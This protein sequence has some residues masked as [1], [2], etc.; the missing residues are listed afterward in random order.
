MRTKFQ[1]PQTTA[2]RK[3]A[4]AEGKPLPPESVVVYP[5]PHQFPFRAGP[6]TPPIVKVGTVIHDEYYGDVA[7]AGM[8]KAPIPWPGFHQTRGLH[9]GVMPILFADLVRA[10]V[11]EDEVVV[12]H[13]WAVSLYTVNNW[14]NAVAGCTDSNGVF[15]ALAVKRA[16]PAFRRK[17]GYR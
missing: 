6:Y 14:K 11:E 16:D 4:R 17:Y 5:P 2:Q 15:S 13:Y 1:T 10:V 12:A 8:S 7:V 3:R 9:V